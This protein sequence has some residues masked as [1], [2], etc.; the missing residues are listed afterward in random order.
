[1]VSSCDAPHCE[2]VDWDAE[3]KSNHR[4]GAGEGKSRSCLEIMAN[5]HANAPRPGPPVSPRPVHVD[6]RRLRC[7]ARFSSSD[8][9]QGGDHVLTIAIE[10]LKHGVHPRR[11][12][13]RRGNHLCRNR[14]GC[15]VQRPRPPC[16]QPETEVVWAACGGWPEP[17]GTTSTCGA[18]RGDCPRNGVSGGCWRRRHGFEFTA[19]L[20]G[21]GLLQEASCRYAVLAFIV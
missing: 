5:S 18:S 2:S 1:M 12:G 21:G 4:R 15:G 11:W 7:A 14:C 6:T 20:Q 17:D 13:L 9:R 19:E 3:H 16:Q 10:D 8:T